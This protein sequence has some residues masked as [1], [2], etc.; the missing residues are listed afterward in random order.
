MKAPPIPSAPRPSVGIASRKTIAPPQ[1]DVNSENSGSDG[2]GHMPVQSEKKEEG[3]KGS[4]AT[5]VHPVSRLA[6]EPTSQQRVNTKGHPKPPSITS[7]HDWL[8]PNDQLASRRIQSQ[9]HVPKLSSSKKPPPRTPTLENPV[10]L[11]T[12]A[13][14]MR[15]FNPHFLLEEGSSQGVAYS[16]ILQD[17]VLRPIRSHPNARAAKAEAA[18]RALSIVEKWPINCH[19]SDEL[20]EERQDLKV[21][22]LVEHTEHNPAQQNS[23]PS[24]QIQP[25][26]NDSGRS[27][28]RTIHSHERVWAYD[29]LTERN[30]QEKLKRLDR[31]AGTNNI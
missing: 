14:H 16:V 12:A 20:P 9:D 30:T 11:L 15:K 5:P 1:Q 22:R 3:S 18:A 8:G 23:K 4:S 2:K 7:I 28:R 29:G 25:S 10:S 26:R 24:Q 21:Y 6:A 19:N 31:V 27:D 17:R 13:C